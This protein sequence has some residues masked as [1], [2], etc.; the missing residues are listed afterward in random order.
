MPGFLAARFAGDKVQQCRIALGGVGSVPWR[1]FRLERELEGQTFDR[2]A[3]ERA[4]KSEMSV[5]RPREHNAFKTV[6]AERAVWRALSQ[7]RGGSDV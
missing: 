5:A 7:L 2:P 3:V 4:V 6:L 1:A